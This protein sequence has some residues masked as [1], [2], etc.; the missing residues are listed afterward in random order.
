MAKIKNIIVE[1]TTGTRMINGTEW[2][3]ISQLVREQ[4]PHDKRPTWLVVYG[5]CNGIPV[6]S[7]KH[8]TLSAARIEFEKIG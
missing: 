7:Q 3:I 4:G 5:L 1:K 8:Q 6:S 2:P